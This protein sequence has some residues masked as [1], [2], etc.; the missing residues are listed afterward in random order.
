M[1]KA[2]VTRSLARNRVALAVNPVSLAI[3]LLRNRA[4]VV[5]LVSQP[6]KVNPLALDLMIQKVIT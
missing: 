4:R 6:Q 3:N 5:H 2:V 1:L